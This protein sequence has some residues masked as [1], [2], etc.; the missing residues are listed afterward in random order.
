MTEEQIE[1]A[2]HE[3][4][5]ECPKYS[6]YPEHM[7]TFKAGANLVMGRVKELE[8]K[9][10]IAVEALEELKLN[11]SHR[12]LDAEHMRRL[13]DTYGWCDFCGT[14]MSFDEDGV[15]NEALQKIKGGG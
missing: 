2:A 4:V 12:N 10:A 15:A 3:F 6:G 14:K 5:N 13:G 8:A 1:K 11:H 9:L 7:I